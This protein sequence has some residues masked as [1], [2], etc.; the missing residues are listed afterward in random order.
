MKFK[1]PS[2]QHTRALVSYS[3]L[4][5][6]HTYD[7]LAPPPL[8]SYEVVSLQLNI[9]HNTTQHS[10]MSFRRYSSYSEI[11]RNLHVFVECTGF[12]L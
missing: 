4:P 8:Y 2:G 3:Q 11:K 7:R 5:M 6:T 9:S 10:D 1:F 12:N